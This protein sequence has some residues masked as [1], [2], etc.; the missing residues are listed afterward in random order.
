MSRFSSCLTGRHGCG[1]LAGRRFTLAES[2][3][4]IARQIEF[5]S[6]SEVR[7]A[8]TPVAEPAS[9]QILAEATRTLI[10]AGTEQNLLEGDHR[11]A[12]LAE[13]PDALRP[14]YSWVGRV[15]EAG[16]EAGGFA[17]GD[18]IV[19]SLQHV[20]AALVP[21]TDR[22]MTKLETP[23]LLPDAVS[24]DAAT[25]VSLADVAL[26]AVRRAQPSIGDAVAVFGVGV[27]GQLIVQFARMAG[28]HPVVA[29]DLDD[30]R[31]EIALASGATHV[32]NAGRE[33][34]AAA[35]RDVSY[36]DGAR[37]V[38]MA[39]RTPLVLPDCIRAADNGGVIAVTGS[40]PGAVGIELQVDLLRRELTIFGTYQA[41]YPHEPYHRF[42]WPRPRNREY[43]IELMARGEL[44]VD[45]LISHRV[46][47]TGAAEM[48]ALI[49]QGPTGWLAIV[50]D[51]TDTS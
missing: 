22:P 21:P 51:W 3:P 23:Q 16:D 13:A 24:D 39:T 36:G 37:A 27:V 31:L 34:A 38:F 10:S 49:E 45:H 46:P 50:L 4:R 18:R 40:A 29:V 15:L 35:I 20:S 44:R 26:H 19:A 12:G 17:A 32:V 11:A 5:P 2:V 9:S 41:F 33:D 30:R 14:G 8:E 25:F 43:V 48:Y 1:I 28:A 47:Y 42:Q 7:I 6:P